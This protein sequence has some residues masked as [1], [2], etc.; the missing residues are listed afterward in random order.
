[1]FSSRAIGVSH[2][3]HG[4][5]EEL[6]G[7]INCICPLLRDAVGRDFRSEEIE[8]QIATGFLHNVK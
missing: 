1:M 5:T 3:G 2:G 8:A 6:F 7:L 4:A